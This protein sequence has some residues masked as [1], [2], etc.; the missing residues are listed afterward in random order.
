M[1][2][3]TW[4]SG[5]GSGDWA[6][7]ANWTPAGGQ[8][9]ADTDGAILTGGT[10]DYTVTIAPTDAFIADAVTLDDPFATL[11]VN[12]G[13][14][15]A[16]GGIGVDAGTLLL[17]QS[18][19]ISDGTITPTDSA[20][21]FDGATLSTITWNGVL[22]LTADV[23]APYGPND[24]TLRIEGTTA[25]SVNPAISLNVVGPDGAPG[26]I[27]LTGNGTR[28]DFVDN[29]T[30]DNAT[31][32]IGAVGT[33]G[34]T[35]RAANSTAFS[36]N[37]TLGPNTVIDQTTP[38]S[39][40]I[41]ASQ[42]SSSVP[43]AATENSF[44]DAGTINAM[45]PGGTLEVTGFL[46]VSGALNVLNGETLLV[47][48]DE[49]NTGVYMGVATFGA[50]EDATLTVDSTSSVLAY[51]RFDLVGTVSIAAGGTF[52][53]EPDAE[54]LS[55]AM[56]SGSLTDNGTL[57]AFDGLLT[58]TGDVTG[59]GTIVAE[60]AGTLDVE[61]SVAGIS[62]AFFPNAEGL[63]HSEMI[64]GQPNSVTTP[65]NNFTAET[66]IDLQGFFLTGSSYVDNVL[67]LSNASETVTIN[68]D[69][70]YGTLLQVTEDPTTGDTI[71]TIACFARGTR[72]ATPLG[73]A[74]VETLR[75]GDMVRLAS[76]EAA[77]IVW[78]GHRRVDCRAQPTPRHV[79]PVRVR[80]DAFAPG[81]PRHD[82]FLSPDH[83]VF[84]EDVLIPIKYLMNRDTIRQAPCDSVAYFHLELPKHDVLLAEGLPVE[85]YL[86]TGDRGSF[87]NRGRVAT[88]FPD[89]SL[90]VWEAYGY[91]PLTVTGPRFEAVRRRIEAQP[92]RP[93]S[94][95]HQRKRRSAA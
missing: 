87:A 4:I 81:V 70:D 62:L 60:E 27:D 92:R 14:A 20:I 7:A 90:R 42:P 76:G 23:S 93:R 5:I 72:I 18:G 73:E 32:D 89:F 22:G 78:I 24:A 80:R 21:A 28:L 49:A 82:L 58:I 1:T 41:I 6:A 36:G 15:L 31:I 2:T 63:Q 50:P 83:A 39:L 84:A 38:N 40:A 69:A 34:A 79:W 65:I 29:Q 51:D 88:L 25:L 57:Y 61:G 55:R 47:D 26:T 9:D 35:L 8:P 56:V 16:G 19:T 74:A 95:P 54:S 66:T 12:G 43:G 94:E 91:A 11:D 37:T 85:S 68:T 64:F 13:L 17:D 30:F 44:G 10:A 77:P 52:V 59:S 33:V 53:L 75:P 46:Q 3:F 48:G 86:D 45:A 71:A 67:T